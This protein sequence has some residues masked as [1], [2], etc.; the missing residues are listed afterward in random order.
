M[1][2]T[3]EDTEHKLGFG[4]AGTIRRLSLLYGDDYDFILN[5]N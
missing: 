3:G 1:K 2:R 5:S 4:L